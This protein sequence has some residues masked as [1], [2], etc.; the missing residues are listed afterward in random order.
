MSS[1]RITHIGSSRD[2][3]MTMLK[4][5]LPSQNAQKNSRVARLVEICSDCDSWMDLELVDYLV[6]GMVA[7]VQTCGDLQLDP[8]SGWWMMSWSEWEGGWLWLSR[9]L[10]VGM[11]E[12][13]RAWSL[14][15]R[16]GNWRMSNWILMALNWIELGVVEVDLFE[17]AE[18]EECEHGESM[19]NEVVI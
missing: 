15:V 13:F 6:V 12:Q 17:H 10:E 14:V 3:R 11:I 16:E 8:D 18:T 5:R 4:S 9:V 1:D 7:V 19:N 2:P